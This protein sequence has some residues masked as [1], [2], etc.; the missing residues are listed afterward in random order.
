MPLPVTSLPDS[1]SQDMSTK[2]PI[3]DVLSRIGEK[4]S[5][6]I[7]LILSKSPKRFRVMLREIDGISQ[8]M[9]TKTLR[10]L[11]R[12]GLITRTVYD[13][14]PPS[15]EYA[16]S[17]LGKSI[18]PVLTKLVEWATH[19]HTQIAEAR[20]IYDEAHISNKINPC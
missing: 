16:L 4:W 20:D 10:T 15:V 9:L 18:L 19:H 6:L 11:E 3:Q 17:P 8:R 5:M 7:L 13:T 12:D 1:Q 14:R 2:C